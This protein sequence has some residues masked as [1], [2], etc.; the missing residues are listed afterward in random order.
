MGIS[1]SS[2]PYRTDSIERIQVLA[3][4]PACEKCPFHAVLDGDH[5]CGFLPCADRKDGAWE[6]HEAEMISI[7]VGIPLYEKTDGVHMDLDAREAADKKLFKDRHADIRLMPAKN[8]WNN[9]DGLNR[10]IKA[11]VVGELAEKRKKKAEKEKAAQPKPQPQPA[12]DWQ[13]ESRI[14]EMTHAFESRFVWEVASPAFTSMLDGIVNLPLLELLNENKWNPGNKPKAANKAD[15]LKHA[16]RCVA[17]SL[18][19]DCTGHHDTNPVQHWGKECKTIAIKLSVKLPK[20][21]DKQVE[22]Y[23]EEYEMARKDIIEKRKAEKK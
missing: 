4:P 2:W 20:D 8:M 12:R 6:K 9:F 23:H 19:I 11:V 1:Y 15:A 10:E 3:N 17:Y 16:R 18:I 7:A 22:K 5:Y 13:L 21:W 14:R